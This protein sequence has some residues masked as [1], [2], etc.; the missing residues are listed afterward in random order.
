MRILS[1]QSLRKFFKARRSKK[2]AFQCKIDILRVA[3]HEIEYTMNQ[4]NIRERYGDESGPVM[5]YC[6]GIRDACWTIDRL[7]KKMEDV[8]DDNKV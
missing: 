3:R 8:A 6:F 1:R 2:S 7:I 4:S 5:W